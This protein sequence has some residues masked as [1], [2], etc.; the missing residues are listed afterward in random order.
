MKQ[1]AK[2]R[3]F[4]VVC[5][6]S[7]PSLTP[8]DLERVRAWRAE[9]P[10]RAVV[11]TNTT[12]FS[13][14]WAD[15]VVAWDSK[16][17][18]KYAGRIW[19]EFHGERF[20]TSTLAPTFKAHRLAAPFHGYGNSGAGAI[21][22]ALWRGAAR[23]LMLGYD[24]QRTDGQTH[25]HGDHPEGMSN[26]ATIDRWPDRFAALAQRAAKGRVIN[27]SRT[28]ALTCFPRANLEDVLC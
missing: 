2:W 22:L 21:S 16:W 23:V 3:D 5:L 24:C 4:T 8:D 18:R 25:H 27:C 20:T 15:A 7:G 17:W 26:A 19:E 10:R 6:A 11:V 13:A 1:D 12:A 14:P 28:T 9:A